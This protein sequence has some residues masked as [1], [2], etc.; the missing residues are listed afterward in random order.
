MHKSSNVLNGRKE[1][2]RDWC[3]IDVTFVGVIRY[4]HYARLK[5]MRE[6]HRIHIEFMSPGKP[7]IWA[8]P[9][10]MALF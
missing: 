3:Y 1:P 5:C 8:N 6:S 2:M 4:S 7:W 9:K 10:S